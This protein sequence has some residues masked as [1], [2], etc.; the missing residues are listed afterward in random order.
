MYLVASVIYMSAYD[1]KTQ[2]SIGEQY[3]TLLD[4]HYSQW[5]DIFS[6]S[7]QAQKAGIDRI[8][9]NKNNGFR[10]SVEYKSDRTASTT[11]N[12]FIETMSV[13]KTNKL[14]WAYTSCSQILVYYLPFEHTA[15]HIT[16]LTI[17]NM[18]EKWERNYSSRSI[19]NG[20]YSTIG[21]LVPINVFKNECYNIHQ[22]NKDTTNA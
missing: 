6:L 3:E 20:D 18:V 21:I 4:N 14:G 19:P 10:Y 8:W 17:K 5:Y 2:L 15:Y 12:V 22:L 13:D 16:T 1:F 11:G 9:V 7:M